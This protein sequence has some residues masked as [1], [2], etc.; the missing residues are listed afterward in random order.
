L[1]FFIAFRNDPALH[2]KYFF[3]KAAKNLKNADKFAFFMSHLTMTDCDFGLL[4]NQVLYLCEYHFIKQRGKTMKKEDY[5]GII[6]FLAELYKRNVVKN[7]FAE[8]VFRAIMEE[9]EPAHLIF[10]S[11]LIF[12][13]I[14]SD[15]DP[16]VSFTRNRIVDLLEAFKNIDDDR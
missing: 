12:E 7:T 5:L 2:S 13:K 3:L 4:K 16:I 10:Y 9:R 8:R 14:T 15:N 11:E 1:F 6:G